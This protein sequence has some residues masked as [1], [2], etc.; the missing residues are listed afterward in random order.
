[1]PNS[2]TVAG[3]TRL[4]WTLTD[5]QTNS[6]VTRSGSESATRAITNGTGPQQANVVWGGLVTVAPSQTTG[7]VFASMP[8]SAFGPTGTATVTTVKEILVF[9]TTTGVTGA[10]LLVGSTGA[11]T[12]TAVNGGG[13]WH[14]ADYA[15]GS[16]PSTWP[17]ST[18]WLRNTT[19]GAIV[20]DVS[21][22]GVGTYS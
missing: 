4:S 1:M 13:Q 20:A 21:V 12:G 9:N 18:L 10:S 15:V 22:I 3:S 2:L 6:S 7:V 19:T 8:V 5:S 17:A 16:A 14:W 11:I